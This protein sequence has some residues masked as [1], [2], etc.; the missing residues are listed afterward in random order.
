M[1]IIEKLKSFNVEITPEI[2]KAFDGDFVSQLEIDKKLEKAEKERDQWKQ[3]AET[4]EGTLKGFE[5]KDFDAMQR[6]V[7]SWKAEAEKAKSDFETKMAEKEKD[8]LLK[9]A[10][11]DVEF[12]SE[13][14]RN[15]ILEKIKSSVSVKNGRLIGFNDLLEEEMKKDASAFKGKD[16]EEHRARFT[17]SMNN[18]KETGKALTKEE[19]SKISNRSERRAQMEAYIAEHGSFLS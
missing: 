8:D 3:R 10:F 12:T 16:P 18:N 15:H 2:Q 7:E 14:A 5:G 4:A 11:K 6:E 19:I 1:N 9:E 13:A 17:N